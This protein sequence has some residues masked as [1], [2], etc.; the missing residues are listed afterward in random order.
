MHQPTMHL[1]QTPVEHLD[2]T[3]FLLAQFEGG[4]NGRKESKKR[5]REMENGSSEKKKK[6]R[7]EWK[8]REG[9]DLGII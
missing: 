7:K 4:G 2:R 3:L 6:I 5:G 1:L 8:G 9:P